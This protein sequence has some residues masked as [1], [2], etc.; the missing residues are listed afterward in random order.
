L[1]WTLDFVTVSCV[2]PAEDKDQLVAVEK[3][4][5]LKDRISKQAAI[6]CTPLGEHLS[7]SAISQPPTGVGF[8]LGSFMSGFCYSLEED[9]PLDYHSR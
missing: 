4:R 9:G 2:T 1:N 5:F 8:I 7:C 6:Y 3:F